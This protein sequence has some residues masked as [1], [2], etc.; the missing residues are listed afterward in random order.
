MKIDMQLLQ[1]VYVAIAAPAL[2]W[3]GGWLQ[4]Q[5]KVRQSRKARITFLKG[6]PD[7]AKLCLMSFYHNKTHTLRGDPNEPVVRY[8]TQM[9]VLHVGTGGGTFDAVDRYLTVMSAYW[10]VLDRWLL[11]DP[12]ALRLMT[13][14]LQEALADE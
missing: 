3:I 6:L 12:I 5:N 9:K 1:W 11:A 13:E 8:L 14:H 4:Q 2:G 10:V 7:E